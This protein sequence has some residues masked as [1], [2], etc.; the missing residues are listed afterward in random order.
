MASL[1]VRDD[2]WLGILAAQ[3]G[4]VAPEAVLAA[5]QSSRE[6]ADSLGD[7]LVRLGAL[8]PDERALLERL[9]NRLTA[10]NLP[11]EPA[12]WSLIL[13]NALNAAASQRSDV[14]S[15][16]DSSVVVPD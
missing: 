1:D 11:L 14:S 6:P 16:T 4:L 2:L 5:A 7:V 12:G 9:R 8:T 3:I 15:G 10:R 13:E